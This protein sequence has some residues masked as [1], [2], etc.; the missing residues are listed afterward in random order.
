MSADEERQPPAPAA[1]AEGDQPKSRRSGQRRGPRHE[2]P[3]EE[4]RQRPKSGDRS[5]SNGYRDGVD[6]AFCAAMMRV[7]SPTGVKVHRPELATMTRP[8][9]ARR[10]GA[11]LRCDLQH[12]GPHIWPDGELVPR[13]DTPTE[14]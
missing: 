12:D 10:E 4:R 1:L 8:I 2:D 9:V 7:L 6:H 5:G 14:A 3:V 11:Q 13:E